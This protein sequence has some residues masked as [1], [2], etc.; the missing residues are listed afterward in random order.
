LY[1]TARCGRLTELIWSY[2]PEANPFAKKT[3][4]GPPKVGIGIGNKKPATAGIQKSLHKSETFFEKVE[5][6]EMSID[7]LNVSENP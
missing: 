3:D 2:F 6:A 5:A 4:M 1:T 7:P